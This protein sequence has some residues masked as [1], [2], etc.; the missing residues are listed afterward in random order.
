MPVKAGVSGQ[1][2]GVSKDNANPRLLGLIAGMGQLPVSIAAEAKK[3]GYYVVGIALQPPADESLKSVA[4]DFYK[5]RIGSLGGLLSLFKK[6]SINEAVMA[7]KVPKK[8]LY[9][10]KKDLIPDLKAMQLLFSLKDHSDDTIMNA[11]V[12]ELEKKHIRIHETITFTKNLLAHEGVLTH[13]K[14]SRD[15]LK[16][17]EFGWAIARKM[18]ELDIGQTIVVKNRAVMAVEAIE[19]TDEAI[20]RGGELAHKHAVVIK[21]SKPGQDMRFDVPAVGIDTLRSMKKANANVLALE[22]LKCIIVDKENFLKEADAE[23]IAV[24]GI[25]SGNI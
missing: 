17:I 16:D 18:G 6:L 5:V 20:K 21:V 25:N 8:L 22:A 1:G 23:G 4:D 7:G 19:G 10:N 11:V 13:R 15:D 14:P 12:K 9:E 24:I 2:S 3:M